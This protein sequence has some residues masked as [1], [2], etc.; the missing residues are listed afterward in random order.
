LIYL[1]V[2]V[3]TIYPESFENDYFPKT[4]TYQNTG[5][6]VSQALKVIRSI[7]DHKVD[8]EFLLTSQRHEISEMISD[9]PKALTRIVSVIVAETMF[10]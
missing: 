6:G 5:E 2:P 7:L 1:G 3:I 4:G 8:R 10:V 9:S